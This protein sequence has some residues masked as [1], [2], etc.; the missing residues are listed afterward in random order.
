MSALGGAV[1]FDL[2]Q[3]PKTLKEALPLLTDIGFSCGDA[4]SIYRTTLRE[5]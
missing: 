1:S 4:P 2:G 3:G 5:K